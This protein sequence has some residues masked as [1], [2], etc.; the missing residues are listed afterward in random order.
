MPRA[1]K[2]GKYINIYMQKDILHAAE[3]Y[4]DDTGVPKTR[5]IE[6]S[7]KEYL[8]KRG[9]EIKKQTECI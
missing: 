5:I 9:V 2:D 8:E 4:S 6:D 7:V 1:K 3:Q